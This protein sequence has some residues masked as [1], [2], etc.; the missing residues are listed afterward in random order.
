MTLSA[1]SSERQALVP[2][3]A[4]L[5]QFNAKEMG[6]VQKALKDP[7]Y[8][9][10]P[11]KEV[12]RVDFSNLF[13]FGS[14]STSEPASP[15]RS[16]GIVAMPPSPVPGSVKANPPAANTTRPPLPP[17]LRLPKEEAVPPSSPLR[18]TELSLSDQDLHQKL[19]KIG[20][21]IL[22]MS[23]S[24]DEIDSQSQQSILSPHDVPE[25]GFFSKAL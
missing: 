12:K 22:D 9:L 7:N 11:V 6:E 24:N 10:K 17:S 4:M 23:M 15:A 5:L 2:V 25:D 21:D 13:S 3:L 18:K 19:T 8:G 1:Q 16:P 14:T 20:G